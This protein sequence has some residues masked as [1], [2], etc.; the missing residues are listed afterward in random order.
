M[1]KM[2]L[3]GA[4]AATSPTNYV[5]TQHFIALNEKVYCFAQ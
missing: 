4:W 3:Q 1:S 5:I 2:A